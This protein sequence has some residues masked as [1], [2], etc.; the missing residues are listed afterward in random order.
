VYK[1]PLKLNPTN[2]LPLAWLLLLGSVWGSTII[3]T[4]HIVSTGHEPLGL[5]FWQ[6]AFGAL[7]LSVIARFQGTSLPMSWVH[8]RFYTIVALVGT[9]IPNTF[10]YMVAA[11]IPAGLLAIGIATVPMFSLLIALV[12]KSERF[13]SL[14]MLGILLG[15]LAILLILGPEADFSSQGIG[16]F[17]LVALIAPVFY[18]I[19]GNYLALKTPPDMHPINILYGASVIGLVICTPLTLAT[20][21][22]VDLSQAWTS[23][24]WG[25]LANSILHVIAYAGYI[26]IVGLSGA[27]FASQVAYVVT[28]SGV[29]LGI[30]IL[31]ES[32]GS[33]I[34]LA[35]GCMLSGLVLVQP[36]KTVS[37]IKASH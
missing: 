17:M 26:W 19:E 34:W 28:L 36:R 5:I 16:L 29:L 9:V 31:G 32:H 23:V 21:S 3:I 8:L 30:I 15:A 37:K 24:E 6:L 1:V 25:I 14:R 7:L 20:G 12:I 13:D 33:L 35:L 10:T 2:L 22:W 11:Y 18:A 27:V 4:K